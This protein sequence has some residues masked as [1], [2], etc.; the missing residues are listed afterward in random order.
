[1]ILAIVLTV[2]NI[3]LFISA[4]YYNRKTEKAYSESRA[5][6]IALRAEMEKELEEGRASL[7]VDY[8][9]NLYRIY[10]AQIL[11]HRLIDEINN[12]LEK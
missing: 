5:K 2:L 12:K 1:M 9:F 6:T 11:I 3:S 7:L 8:K 10:D 4:L